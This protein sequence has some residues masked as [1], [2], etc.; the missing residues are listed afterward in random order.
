[1]I[2]NSS[3]ESLFEVVNAARFKRSKLTGE[4][5][6]EVTDDEK[7]QVYRWA[8]GGELRPIVDTNGHQIVMG[9]LK[10]YMDDAVHDL[11]VTDPSDE[12]A[13]LRRHGVAFASTYI[14]SRLQIDIDADLKAAETTPDIVKEGMKITRGIPAESV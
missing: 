5:F 8:D 2:D 14:L 11:V 3:I 13:I 12:K 10:K 9:K 4:P 1:M 7:S 6:P